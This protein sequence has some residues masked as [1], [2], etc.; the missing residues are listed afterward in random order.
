ME[1]Q[2]ITTNTTTN[3]TTAQEEVAPVVVGTD[4]AADGDAVV[5]Q[6]APE[7]T[8]DTGPSVTTVVGLGL[9]LALVVV[10]VVKLR[11]KV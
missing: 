4:T 2:V 10:A 7:A 3:T 6:P 1:N 5:E 8:G 9:V 11:S